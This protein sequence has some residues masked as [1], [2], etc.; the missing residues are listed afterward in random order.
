MVNGMVS[1]VKPL[2]PRV[3]YWARTATAVKAS[4]IRVVL[5]LVNGLVIGSP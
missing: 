4:P 5:I 2:R 3:R 1:K